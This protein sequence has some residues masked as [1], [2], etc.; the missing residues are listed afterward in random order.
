MIIWF[1]TASRFQ[2]DS[3][4]KI[5]TGEKGCGRCRNNRFTKRFSRYGNWR[6][7]RYGIMIVVLKAVFHENKN[8]REW[9]EKSKIY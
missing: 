8:R 1:P 4:L 9:T 2:V 6:V 7:W 3:H 5:E